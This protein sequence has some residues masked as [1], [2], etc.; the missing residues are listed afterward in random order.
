MRRRDAA[1]DREQ[2]RD[3]L[4]GGADD[5][6][7]R[8]VDDHHAAGGRGRDVDVVEPDAGPGDHLQLRRGRERLGVDRGRAADDERVGLGQRR[9]QRGAVGAVDVP[10]LEVRGQQ[11]EPGGRELFGDQNNGA[12]GW[13]ILT[14][15]T[16]SR[17]PASLSAPARA[18]QRTGALSPSSLAHPSTMDRLVE[19]VG[20]PAHQRAQLA[21]DLLDR[22]VPCP[23]R[24]SLVKFG[25]PASSSAIHSRANE[26]S[27]ISP[28]IGSSPPWWRR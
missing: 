20:D 7:L 15:L 26:P 28:R 9:Q 5:V 3:R 16:E 24:R 25:R 2:Q 17:Y 8:R 21:A 11:V 19:R 4:L 13:Q 14:A 18:R 6:G 10:D 1:G 23:A 12:T 27:W 22:V